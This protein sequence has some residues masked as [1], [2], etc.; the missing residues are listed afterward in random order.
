MLV[1]SSCL[2]IYIYIYIL[3]IYH[4]SAWSFVSVKFKQWIREILGWLKYL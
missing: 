4:L 1:F 3:H 2:Y